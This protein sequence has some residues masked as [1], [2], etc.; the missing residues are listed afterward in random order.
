MLVPPRPRASSLTT[1]SAERVLEA[2]GEDA[3]PRLQAAVAERQ[4]AVHDERDGRQ[5]ELRA[6]GEVDDVVGPI[7]DVRR[8]DGARLRPGE[9]DLLG[10]G[11]RLPPTGISE[12]TS[13]ASVAFR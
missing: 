6:G 2:D 3:A 9:R 13:T 8:G 7:G 5:V 4:D 12:M 1:G 10:E 11:E